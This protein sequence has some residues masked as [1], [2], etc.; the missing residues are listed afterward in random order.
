MKCASVPSEYRNCI[1][2]ASVWIERNFS[3]AR[4]VLSMTLPSDVRRSF[5]RTNAPPLPGLTCW[6]S[7]TL[8]I[9][10]S[11]SMWFPFLSWLVL[12]MAAGQCRARLLVRAFA[13]VGAGAAGPGASW[14]VVPARRRLR[15]RPGG[16]RRAPARGGRR[17]SGVDLEDQA[18][19]G[20]AQVGA[21][22]TAVGRELDVDVGT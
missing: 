2:R 8:K 17:A 21:V 12:I 4:K 5:V 3:P 18:L 10:P 14:S 15:G 13:G 20:P 1:L 19:G 22:R 7:S 6:N 16:W 11:T 9:V